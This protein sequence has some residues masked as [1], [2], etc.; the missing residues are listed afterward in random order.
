VTDTLFRKQRYAVTAGFRLDPSLFGKIKTAVANRK[1]AGIA[2]EKSLDQAR[3]DVVTAH[4]AS[5]TAYKLIPDAQRELTSSEEALRLSQQELKAGTG[6]TIGVLQAESAVDQARMHYA[7]AVVRYN[8]AQVNLLAALG[9][10]DSSNIGSAVASADAQ[11][12]A[13]APPVR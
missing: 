10:L 5:V 1:V 2:L 13:E 9:L 12:E 4:Q 11:R 6:L 8:Q 3:A 7:I